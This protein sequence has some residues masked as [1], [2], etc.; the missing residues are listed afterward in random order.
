ME[1]LPLALIPPILTQVLNYCDLA[2]QCSASRVCKHWRAVF[3]RIPKEDLD[4]FVYVLTNKLNTIPQ[5]W[6]KAKQY[7]DEL[8]LK[9]KR[10]ESLSSLSRFLSK[11]TPNVVTMA[12]KDFYNVKEALESIRP[13]GDTTSGDYYR[14]PKALSPALDALVY[15]CAKR[16]DPQTA[17]KFA[18]WAQYG[19]ACEE[20][21]V[22]DLL[23]SRAAEFSFGSFR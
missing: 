18:E 3:E 16:F 14:L 4:Q 17:M 9:Q 11:H 1:S 5:A 6:P 7:P 23:S 20:L 12:A 10:A 19:S 13:T 21:E 15:T 8:L 2:T 22:D